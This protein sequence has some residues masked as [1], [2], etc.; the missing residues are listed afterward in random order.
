[1]PKDK[2]QQQK[3][4][5]DRV[6]AHQRALSD[7][8]KTIVTP[9]PSPAPKKKSKTP[10]PEFQ[11]LKI[12]KRKDWDL[13]LKDFNTI[14]GMSIDEKT[15]A[16]IFPSHDA[17]VAFFEKQ[18]IAGY[19]FFVAEYIGGQPSGFHLFSCG[20]GDLYKGT[21]EEIREQLEIAIKEN[22]QNTKASA[23]LE[24]LKDIIE[25]ASATLGDDN[26]TNKMR[27]SLNEGRGENLLEPSSSPS[28][29]GAR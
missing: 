8:L 28:P 7:Q 20:D 16:L 18:A 9:T 13:I 6:I 19:E 11:P 17:A 5:E 4:Q 27:D 22:P 2:E 23:G 1:M 14:K 21:L 15:G 10:S 29:K 25:A 24:S 12:K 26:P 3:E